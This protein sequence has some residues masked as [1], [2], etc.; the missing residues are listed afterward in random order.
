M[1]NIH[2]DLQRDLQ[3]N[4]YYPQLKGI[5]REKERLILERVETEHNTTPRALVVI[6]WMV[7]LLK[8]TAMH[9]R[10]NETSNFYR[11]LDILMTFKK[12]CGNTIKV[13]FVIYSFYMTLTISYLFC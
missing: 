13:G 1:N 4:S 7:L 12:S 3:N 2:V 10:F 8:E 11:V 5:I 9:N 6:D